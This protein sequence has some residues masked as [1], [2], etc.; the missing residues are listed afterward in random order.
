[1]QRGSFVHTSRKYTDIYECEDELY[2]LIRNFIVVQVLQTGLCDVFVRY[3]NQAQ[4]HSQI[5]EASYTIANSKRMDVLERQV[6]KTD[7]C[8][9][10]SLHY[11]S[12]RSANRDERTTVT[13]VLQVSNVHNSCSGIVSAPEP[14][15]QRACDEYS[16]I[17]LDGTCYEN[18]AGWSF[19]LCFFACI[20]WQSYSSSACWGRESTGLISRVQ[21][22]SSFVWRVRTAVRI[23]FSPSV[24]FQF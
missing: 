10:S 9:S 15:G 19:L 12:A 21:A 3:S 13:T 11:S 5:R 16:H 24:L 20:R 7:A 22:C 18:P 2:V 4:V 23:V 8:V 1:M 17:G 6:E 14:R